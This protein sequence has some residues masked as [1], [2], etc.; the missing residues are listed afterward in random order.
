MATRNH[1]TDRVE[2]YSPESLHVIR[3]AGLLTTDVG[4]WVTVPQHSDYTVQLVVDSGT[5]LVALVIEGSNAVAAPVTKNIGVL[6]D[7]RFGTNP[8]QFAFADGGKFR[9]GG[10]APVQIRPNFSGAGDSSVSVIVCFRKP[11]F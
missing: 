9:Q 7:A 6:N 11:I 8:M 1:V 10:E 5:T 2:G 4:D 3:W